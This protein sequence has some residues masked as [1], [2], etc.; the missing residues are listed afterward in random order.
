[1]REIRPIPSHNPEISDTRDIKEILQMSKV[2][3]GWAF[4]GK[5]GGGRVAGDRSQTTDKN[6][7]K[8]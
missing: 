3:V 5:G 8:V 1:M 7:N 2:A 4:R 6:L